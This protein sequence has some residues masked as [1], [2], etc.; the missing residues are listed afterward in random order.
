MGMPADAGV[1]EGNED[2]S[3]GRGVEAGGGTRRGLLEAATG[4][5]FVESAAF[6]A[7]KLVASGLEVT[8]L[9]SVWAGSG[10]GDVKAIAKT[11]MRSNLP[12]CPYL[13]VKSTLSICLLD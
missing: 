11:R 4:G 8:A 10:R 13:E 9:V 12:F 5:A 1:D 7:S 2:G 6:P 3:D